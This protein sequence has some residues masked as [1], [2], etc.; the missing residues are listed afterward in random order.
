MEGRGSTESSDAVLARLLASADA[1]G[2]RHIAR[3]LDSA[4]FS[5]AAFERTEDGI[6]VAYVNHAASAQA[7]IGGHH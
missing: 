7:A 1:G 5:V 4:A 6:C 3:L 2:V